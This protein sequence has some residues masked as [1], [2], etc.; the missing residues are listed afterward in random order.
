MAKRGPKP[1]GREVVWSAEFAYAVGLMVADGNLSPDGRHLECTSKDFE[2]LINL[3]R[4]LGITVKIRTKKSG[5]RGDKKKYYRLLWGDVILYNFLLGIGLMPNKSKIIGALAIPDKFFFDFLRGHHD[6]DGSFS[7]Y[8]DPRWGKS[9]MFYLTF[10]SASRSHIEWLRTTLARLIG[11]KGHIS[12]DGERKIYHLRFAKRESTLLLQRMYANM[13]AV[14]LSRKRLK[15]ERALRIVG[16]S[17]LGVGQFPQ[18]YA[19]VAKLVDVS[20]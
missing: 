17:L 15:I 8:F 12:G 16:L 13:S 3:Q 2:Q 10:V 7:S 20:P 19:R 5:R 11:V 6:G 1:K 18:S 14:H 9:F 4:C